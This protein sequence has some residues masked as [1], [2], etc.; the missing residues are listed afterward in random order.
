MRIYS[1][2]HCASGALMPMGSAGGAW[3]GGAGVV[4]QTGTLFKHGR[5]VAGGKR[6]SETRARGSAAGPFCFIRC[7]LLVGSVTFA[8]RGTHELHGPPAAGEA[9]ATCYLL[10]RRSEENT[11]RKIIAALQ[12][13]HWAV[14]SC[15]LLLRLLFCNCFSRDRF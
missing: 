5:L 11:G 1:D 13:A 14:L 3:L 12:V 4:P 8:M 9:S 7:C 6:E 2:R 15:Y 10:N